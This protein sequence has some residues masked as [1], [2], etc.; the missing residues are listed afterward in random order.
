MSHD[1]SESLSEGAS[2]SKATRSPKT[3]VGVVISVAMDK[4]AVARVDRR[5]AHKRLK[6]VIVRSSRLYVHDEANSLSVGDR[7]RIV[8]TRPLS[9]LKRWRL[10]EILRKAVK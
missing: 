8:E 4:T 10:D 2:A 6:K 5:V 1:T 3:R 9:K 7:I